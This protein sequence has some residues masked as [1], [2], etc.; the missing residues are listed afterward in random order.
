MAK[1]T[2]GVQQ[3]LQ[4]AAND[5][6]AAGLKP[7]SARSGAAKIAR[8]NAPGTGLGLRFKR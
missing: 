7:E 6:P 1:Q 2:P 4:Y 3:M 5:R 8:E